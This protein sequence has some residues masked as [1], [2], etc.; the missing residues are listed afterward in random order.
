MQKD[1]STRRI[2][3][4]VSH[5]RSVCRTLEINAAREHLARLD[6]YQDEVMDVVVERLW[7][8]LGLDEA[9]PQRRENDPSGKAS[10]PGCVGIHVRPEVS[11]Q[12]SRRR[13]LSAR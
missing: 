13:S 10:V 3:R 8:A 6:D 4:P 12:L 7:D 5:R 11:D 1:Q 9:V 2:A